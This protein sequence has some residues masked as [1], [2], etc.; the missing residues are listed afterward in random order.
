MPDEH[1]ESRGI[2]TAADAMRLL[3]P[4][5]VLRQH[6]GARG[7][8]VVCSVGEPLILAGPGGTGKSWLTLIWACA[9]AEG[10]ARDDELID[11]AQRESEAAAEAAA[12]AENTFDE[13]VDELAEVWA[14][15]YGEQ[16]SAIE[17]AT[18]E[19]AEAQADVVSAA[20]LKDQSQV[21]QEAAAIA[22]AEATTT[23]SAEVA[24]A[25]EYA[26]EAAGDA[27]VAAQAQAVWEEACGLAVRP[28][29]VLLVSYEDRPARIAAR[30][31][32]M[33]VSEGA[34]KRLHIAIDPEPLW[35][36]SDRAAGGACVTAAFRAL[37]EQLDALRPSLVVLDPISAAAGSLNLNDGG[38]ARSAVRSLARLSADRGVGFL[39]VAH[40]TKSARESARADS[41]RPG[42]LPGAGAVA[43]SAQWFDAM[44]GVLYLR[45]GPQDA[46]NI[47]RELV[48]LKVNNG[49]D[50]WNVPLARDN[51][52]EGVFQGFRLTADTRVAAPTTD[53]SSRD[54]SASLP[55]EDILI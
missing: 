30:L 55:E 45:L 36:P 12:E 5:P 26:M 13:R 51:N 35:K 8:T 39:V 18:A 33:R 47:D 41:D 9:G 53:E 40:D 19:E 7:G 1:N 6:V 49:V 44:R 23:V 37:S 50:G 10:A 42:R 24:A 22:R 15:G 31:R 28:G 2:I 20:S 54:A 14:E 17:S 25:A 16:L 46:P 4:E 52:D 21:A 43:G 48:A 11:A 32:R 29:P 38:A 3:E 34:L 27:E